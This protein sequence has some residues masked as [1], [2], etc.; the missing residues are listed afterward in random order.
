MKVRTSTMNRKRPMLV[1]ALC[2]PLLTGVALGADA[3]A[4][5]KKHCG[6]CHGPD[7]KGETKAGK[8][9]GAKDMTDAAY[10]KDRTDEQM[11]VSLRDGMEVDGKEAMKP[12][13]KKLTEEEMK[14][15]VGFVRAFQKK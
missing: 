7:G 10:G 2:L 8:K 9:A 3:A 4:N 5:W 12:F 1:A 6:S 14:A 11:L 15:L 13:A